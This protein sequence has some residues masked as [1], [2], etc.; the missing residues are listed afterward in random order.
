MNWFAAR[1][2]AEENTF[3]DYKHVRSAY[4]KLVSD[5]PSKTP[6]S[7]IAGIVFGVASTVFISNLRALSNANGQ[8]EAGTLNWLGISALLAVVA[9]GV[10][11]STF[12]R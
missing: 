7:T 2:R 9:I 1:S 11:V 12:K 5:E 6:W 10:L 3:V 4:S 8:P